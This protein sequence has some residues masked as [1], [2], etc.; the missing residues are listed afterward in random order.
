MSFWFLDLTVNSY[1]RKCLALCHSLLCLPPLPQAE[2]RVR[3]VLKGCLCLLPSPQSCTGSLIRKVL[4]TWLFG[5]L[6]VRM[7]GPLRGHAWPGGC[8]STSKFIIT[9]ISHLPHGLLFPRDL[10]RSVFAPS[11]PSLTSDCYRLLPHTED[12]SHGQRLSPQGRVLWS[13]LAG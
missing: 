13:E 5:P 1:G 10:C 11:T 4:A 12:V 7:A 8:A 2:G 6:S 3:G 9:A